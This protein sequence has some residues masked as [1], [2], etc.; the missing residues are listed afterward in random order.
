MPLLRGEELADDSIASGELC[1]SWNLLII[2]ATLP[3]GFATFAAGEALALLVEGGVGGSNADFK[4]ETPKRSFSGGLGTFDA[5][6]GLE[7]LL[8]V[9]P[10]TN[11]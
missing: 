1:F 9:V 10:T 5:S 4:L 11:S 8:F 7:E 6:K 2:A 3:L